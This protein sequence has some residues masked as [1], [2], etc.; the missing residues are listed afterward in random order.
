MCNVGGI[1]RT[2]GIIA[3][4]FLIS[5]VFIGDQIFAHNMAW[6]WIGLVPLA[7]GIFRFCNFA[8]LTQFLVLRPVQLNKRKIYAL[9]QGRN[10]S[11]RLELSHC[12]SFS[13]C[14]P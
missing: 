4:L 6:G 5:L 1:D 8:L 9:C 11:N 13:C 14:V 10:D 3:G 7:T 2:A 12:H